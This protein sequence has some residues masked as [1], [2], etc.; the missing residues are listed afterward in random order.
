MIVI[1]IGRQIGVSKKTIN[2]VATA[3]I[4]GMALKT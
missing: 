1:L 4:I 2:N 3:I